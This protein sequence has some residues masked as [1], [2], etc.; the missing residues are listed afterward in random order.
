MY[1]FKKKLK[2]KKIRSDVVGPS[3]LGPV[4]RLIKKSYARRPLYSFQSLMGYPKYFKK[5][6]THRL[7]NP[8]CGHCS[9]WKNKILFLYPK[10]YF[11]S[12]FYSKHL[13]NLVEPINNHQ[14]ANKQE[15]FISLDLLF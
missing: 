9:G 3:N 8:E 5:K 15:F 1:Y 6:K 10:S 4:P 7:Q 11:Q 13:R 12:I 14:K 2:I